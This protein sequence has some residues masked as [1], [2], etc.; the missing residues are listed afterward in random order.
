MASARHGQVLGTCGSLYHRHHGPQ[1]LLATGTIFSLSLFFFTCSFIDL[2]PSLYYLLIVQYAI[3]YI[4]FLLF[5]VL[6]FTAQLWLNSP[7]CFLNTLCI[8]YP[9]YVCVHMHK[10]MHACKCVCKHACKYAWKC[11]FTYVFI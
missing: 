6:L 2:F 8:F 10:R 3:M 7:F 4:V 5:F 9:R 1:T 11:A